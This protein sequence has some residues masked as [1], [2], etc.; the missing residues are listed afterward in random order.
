M[1]SFYCP[2]KDMA[3][4]FVSDL[5][6]AVTPFCQRKPTILCGDSNIDFLSEE[7]TVFDPLCR[8]LNFTQL[9]DEATHRGHCLDNILVNRPEICAETGILAPIEAEHS[10]TW[11][12]LNKAAKNSAVRTFR[13]INWD[14]A[15]WGKAR[16]FLTID[17]QTGEERD[18]VA[19]MTDPAKS[20][21][22]AANYLTTL[23]QQAQMKALSERAAVRTVRLKRESCPWM[24]RELFRNIQKK[25]VDYRKFRRNPSPTSR[26][27]MIKSRKR[28]K[29]ECKRAKVNYCQTLFAAA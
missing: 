6:D 1:A 13:R 5:T 14:L 17:S 16:T 28:A 3:P 9:I 2:R 24:S 20:V 25:H 22:D 11:L 29:F 19:A 27:I 15:D 12:R 26:A 4:N 23:V 18:I 21:D 10:V 8:H 7:A